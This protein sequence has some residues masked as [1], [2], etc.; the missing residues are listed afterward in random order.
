MS[1]LAQPLTVS[2]LSTKIRVDIG[3]VSTVIEA[4][5]L[6]RAVAGV[7]QTVVIQPG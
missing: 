6:G 1:L 7:N 3:P 2:I 5:A 4:Q